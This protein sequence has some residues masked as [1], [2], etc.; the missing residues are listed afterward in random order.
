[1]KTLALGVTILL[2]GCAASNPPTD[3]H[4]RSI[5][6]QVQSEDISDREQQCIK[7]AVS[8][9][10]DPATQRAQPDASAGQ[11]AQQS[12]A[13]DEDREISRCKDAAQRD[14][15]EL[16][17]RERSAY[18]DEAQQQRDRASLMAILTTSRP[19]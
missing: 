16:A 8:R 13:D 4:A 18:Q 2:A 17:A 3:A 12:G 7:G 6:F 14:Q 15:A 5:K 19:Q 1:M 10:N 9:S 11:L